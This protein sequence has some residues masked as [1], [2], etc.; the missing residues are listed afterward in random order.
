MLKTKSV[1]CIREYKKIVE[2]VKNTSG[3]IKQL[4][5]KLVSRVAVKQIQKNYSTPKL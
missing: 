1:L 3:N 2:L 4:T 5:K